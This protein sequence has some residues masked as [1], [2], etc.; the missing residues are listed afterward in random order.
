VADVNVSAE[1]DVDLERVWTVAGTTSDI[2]KRK[3]VVIDVNG[4]QILVVAH[5]GAFYA[6]DNICI[7]KQRELSKGVVLNGKLVCPGHQWAFALDSGWEAIKQVCQPTHPVRVVDDLV[8]VG[9]VPASSAAIVEADAAGDEQSVKTWTAAWG[10]EVASVDLAAARRRFADDVAAFGTHADV[11]I[12]RAALEAEQWSKVWPTIED[13]R[14]L[15]DDMQVLVSPDRLQAV[16]VVGWSSTGI[17]QDGAR[18]DRPGRAT[19]VL[20][21]ATIDEPW[22]GHHT[23]FSLGRGVPQS[24]HGSRPATQ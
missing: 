3:R 7:H 1:A 14:F 21:R 22:L 15:V 17:S 10:H 6:F 23:H 11:V 9:V 16:G 18:F 13:F 2:A 5:D 12:G 8:H 20:R 4:R 19:I 24:S